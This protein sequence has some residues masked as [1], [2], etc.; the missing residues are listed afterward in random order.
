[1]TTKFNKI[2]SDL[3]IDEFNLQYED[4]VTYK[5]RTVPINCGRNVFKKDK[6]IFDIKYLY[7][8]K[9]IDI[10]IYTSRKTTGNNIYTSLV[11]FISN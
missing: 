1:M 11:L 8:T 9:L 3:W 6:S 5:S 10:Y 4:R 7:N 2:I